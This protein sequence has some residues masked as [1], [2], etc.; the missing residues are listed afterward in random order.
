LHELTANPAYEA[1]LAKHNALTIERDELKI[2]YKDC[3][4]C[5]TFDSLL[6]KYNKERRM[7]TITIRNI[8]MKLMLIKT[9]AINRISKQKIK[10][11]DLFKPSI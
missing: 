4:D 8:T 9:V 2:H 6:D 5:D 11:E 10:T 1:L 3:V 7:P